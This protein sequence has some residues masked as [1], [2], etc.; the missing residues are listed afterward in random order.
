MGL[1]LDK[2]KPPVIGAMTLVFVSLLALVTY[3]NLK[4]DNYIALLK[5]DVLGTQV[6]NGTEKLN[7]LIKDIEQKR[8]TDE[9]KLVASMTLL[10][11]KVTLL[12]AK[13]LELE[14]LLLLK[15][16]K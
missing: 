14:Q 3:T 9:V 7:T 2:V 1:N 10:N 13:N 5:I 8:I 15:K 6:N 12:E 4:R 16:S 11:D